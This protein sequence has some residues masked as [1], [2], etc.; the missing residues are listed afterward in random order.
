MIAQLAWRNVW[1]N[2]VRSLVVIIATAL[3]IAG[4]LFIGAL[5][6]GMTD[7]WVAKIIDT[8][9]S[10]IQIHNK[11]FI[12]Q[13]DQKYFFK[14]SELENALKTFGENIISSSFRIRSEGLAMSA[15][16]SYQVIIL[17]V[18]P[19]S[20]KKVTTLYTYLTEG[21]YFKENSR[22]KQIIISEKLAE[23]LKVRM[24]SKLVINMSDMEGEIVG[25]AFKVV[26]IYNTS[27][28]PYDRNHVFMLNSDISPFL[29]LEKGNYHELALRIDPELEIKSITEKI[30]SSLP[31]GFLVES[32]QDLNPALEM[33][34][35]YM[36]TFNFILLSVVLIALIFGIINTM[37]MVVLERTREIG[38]LRS[39]GMNDKK[40]GIMFILET[41]YLSLTGA[42]AGNLISFGLITHFGIKGIHFA[43]WE[44]GFESFGY[45]SVVFPLLDTN[46]YFMVTFLVFFTALLASYFPVRK[47]I[48]LD[49]S[50]AIR[51]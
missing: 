44:E 15:H 3:G 13:E 50:T 35:G 8:E 28:T 40:V 43:G 31:E 45:D 51:N 42:I 25:E 27:N 14:R 47:A 16:N 41:I 6:V 32:W 21:E 24:K 30:K 29:K 12:E 4:A 5:M 33:T 19:E 1:R 18:D 26:G 9:V 7:R 46:Y 23:E 49:I 36:D 22:I 2:K 38:M 10:D 11:L 37:L 34:E 20:E 48:G 39:L 17:G